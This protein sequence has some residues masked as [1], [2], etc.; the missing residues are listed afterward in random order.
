VSLRDYFEISA[1]FM[2]LAALLLLQKQGSVSEKMVLDFVKKQA[3]DGG[4][5]ES[6]VCLIISFPC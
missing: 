1:K 2:A 5:L 4:K 3:I 6:D